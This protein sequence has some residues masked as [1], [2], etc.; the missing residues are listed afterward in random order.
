MQ[1]KVLMFFIFYSGITTQKSKDKKIKKLNNKNKQK[2]DMVN[3]NLLLHRIILI[4][5]CRK[6]D[7]NSK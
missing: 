2:E 5:N 6:K 1:S 3:F 4:I 7:T